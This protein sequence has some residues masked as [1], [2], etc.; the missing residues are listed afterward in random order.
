MSMFFK[1][2]SLEATKLI[3]LVTREHTKALSPRE[4]RH[5]LAGYGYG[6]EDTSEGVIVTK[7][8]FGNA[9]CMI[10]NAATPA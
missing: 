9:L 2:D 1:N 8:P 10:P 4:L 7:L 6:L 5:R 3:S